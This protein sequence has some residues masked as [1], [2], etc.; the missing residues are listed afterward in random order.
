MI[1]S[2][3]DRCRN[4]ES[5]NVLQLYVRYL[6]WHFHPSKNQFLHTQSEGCL[7]SHLKHLTYE[8]SRVLFFDEWKNW[9]FLRSR[10]QEKQCDSQTNQWRFF[11]LSVIDRAIWNWREVILHLLVGINITYI[12]HA[13]YLTQLF[14]VEQFIGT[15]IQ[16]IIFPTCTMTQTWNVSLWILI[17]NKK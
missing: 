10:K 5:N 3:L 4:I 6:R 2:A 9:N 14:A 8:E 17:E 11:N 15:T 13:S 16:E 1:F 12:T 7:H